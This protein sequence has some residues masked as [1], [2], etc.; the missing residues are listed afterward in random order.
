[1]AET[2]RARTALWK[3][4]AFAGALASLASATRLAG[5][6]RLTRAQVGSRPEAVR[7]AGGH[8]TVEVSTPGPR[9]DPLLAR[10]AIAQTGPERCELIGQLEPSEDTRATYAI[11]GMLERT[12]FI[13]VRVCG[14]QALALQPTAEARSWLVD[15]ADDPEPAVHGVA[16]DALAAS[17]DALAR[18]TVIEATHSDDGEVR[19]SAVISLLKAGREEAFSALPSIL[20]GIEDRTT[21]STLIDALGQSHDT[22]ALPLLESL[23]DTADHD[24]HLTAISALGEL[25]AS[26]AIPRLDALLTV[27]SED[28]FRNAADALGKLQPAGALARFRHLLGSPNPVREALALSELMKLDDPSILSLMSEQLRSGDPA[29][30]RTVLERLTSK[31]EPSLEAQLTAIASA[32]SVDADSRP[33]QRTIRNLALRALVEIGSA[34]ALA[35][36][37]EVGGSDAERALAQGSREASESDADVRAHRIAA[38]ESDPSPHSL[39]ELARDPAEAAQTA[40][41]R[42]VQ[43]SSGHPERLAY[44][45]SI[46]SVSTVL[47]FVEHAGA[48]DRASKRSL[49]QTLA[50]RGEPR[51]S[52]TLKDALRDD[53]AEIRQAALRGLANLGDQSS[54]VEAQ[55]LARAG[56]PSERTF[57]VELLNARADAASTD[58]LSRLAADPSPEVAS[59]ALLALQTRAPDSVAQL[60]QRAFRNASTEDRVTLL[61]SLVELKGNIARPLYDLALSEGD[62]GAALQAVQGLINLSGPES[63]QRLLA[64]TGNSNGSPDV[65]RDAATG[66]RQLGGPLARA[67]RA[68]LDSLS[69]PISNG[70]YE[71]PAISE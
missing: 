61:S 5:P 68:L 52:A 16:F 25:G 27:G 28:E 70:A 2:A 44:F 39:I 59:S 33:H 26:A 23:I 46:A 65:R 60:A 41:L 7:R 43:H 19:V 24:S 1:M 66:L 42:Y 20:P 56:K 14:A 38:L 55:R 35:T 47:T 22:R 3:G 48:L 69:E 4:W 64:L 18:A 51:F 6:Q 37:K 15:L 9:I 36:V 54:A 67:N 30:I 21:L 49:V 29:C 57:A 34:S 53:D 17:S 58:E 40:V 12:Q 62:E 45:A 50:Q 71:C 32:R 10:L 8:V 63:A 13:S 11:T 31:A